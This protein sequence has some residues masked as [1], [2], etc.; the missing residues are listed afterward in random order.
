MFSRLVFYYPMVGLINLFLN[1]L[2]NP[3]ALTA[4]SDVAVLD[5]VVGH[6][7]HLE[8]LTSSEL[9][10]PFAREVA[11]LAYKTVRKVKTR[12]SGFTRTTTPAD[13][14]GQLSVMDFSNVNTSR[15]VSPVFILF[16]MCHWTG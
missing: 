14:S 12:D 1:I 3:S 9:A 8:V 2:K 4:A 10:Y 7:G 5:I 15:E 13:K 16:F 6:F 11:A